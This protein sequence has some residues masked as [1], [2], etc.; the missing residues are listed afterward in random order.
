MVEF[1]VEKDFFGCWVL[2]DFFEFS[3]L[4]KTMKNKD[5]NMKRGKIKNL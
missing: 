1:F 5:K 2:C 3:S 4:E